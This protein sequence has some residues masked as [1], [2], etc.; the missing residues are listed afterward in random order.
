MKLNYYNFFQQKKRER[1][2]ASKSTYNKL[3]LYK[4]KI[5]HKLI[6]YKQ[7]K[8]NVKMNEIIY[9]YL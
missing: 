6:I 1:L 3:L 5:Q 4:Y 9:I 2:R 7:S 8:V